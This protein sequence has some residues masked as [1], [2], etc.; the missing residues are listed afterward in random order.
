MAKYS[1]NREWDEYKQYWANG[2]K[3]TVGGAVAGGLVG[4]VLPVGMTFGALSG[5]AV[6]L[7]NNHKTVRMATSMCTL[8]LLGSDKG[9]RQGNLLEIAE[10]YERVNDKLIDQTLTAKMKT[11]LALEDIAKKGKSLEERMD[12]KERNDAVEDEL[13]KLKKKLAGEKEDTSES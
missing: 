1:L 3:Y 7:Y 8:G 4:M 10:E 9:N 6:F 5:L 11:Q 2:V 12:D 13:A